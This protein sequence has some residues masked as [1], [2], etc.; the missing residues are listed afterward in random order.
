MVLLL[1]CFC[2]QS[3]YPTHPSKQLKFSIAIRSNSFIIARL[4]YLRCK[5]VQGSV[6]GRKIK[7]NTSSAVWNTER[8]Y[9]STPHS[10]LHHPYHVAQLILVLLMRRLSGSFV[11]TSLLPVVCFKHLVRLVRSV[12]SLSATTVNS[13]VNSWAMTGTDSDFASTWIIRRRARARLYDYDFEVDKSVHDMTSQDGTIWKQ[14][15]QRCAEKEKTANARKLFVHTASPP[16]AK[17]EF[18]WCFVRA[19]YM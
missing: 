9:N 17:R 6:S 18:R 15:V 13:L 10:Y 8:K 11:V 4:S 19:A 1:V 5:K 2:N 14:S 3:F 16:K 7:R 12:V